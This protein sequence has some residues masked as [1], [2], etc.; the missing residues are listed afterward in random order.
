MNDP[1]VLPQNPQPTAMPGPSRTYVRDYRKRPCHAGTLPLIVDA[2]HRQ[3]GPLCLRRP[4]VQGMGMRREQQLVD[5]A[6]ALAVEAFDDDE[7]VWDLAR[8]ARGDLAAVDAACD[9]CIARPVS[10]A[11]RGRAIGL[12]ARVRYRDL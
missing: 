10:L 2:I 1:V 12:L 3:R 8:L 5:Q 11:T 9:L 4:T 7:A 6:L